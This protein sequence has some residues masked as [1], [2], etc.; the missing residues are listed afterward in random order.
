MAHSSPSTNEAKAGG[1][2][3]RHG[4][5]SWK[6]QPYKL[7]FLALGL[8]IFLWGTAYKLSLY[9]VH[10]DHTV[11]VSA[12][13]LWEDTRSTRTVVDVLRKVNTE[14]APSSSILSAARQQMFLVNLGLVQQYSPRLP[15]L[16]PVVPFHPS[17]APPLR[18][19]CLA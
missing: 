16:A 13:R 14:R 17:R 3:G 2:I 18:R 9:Q 5:L 11:R 10:W 4:L 6:L 12:A 7:G 15:L 1:E 8:A 19:F